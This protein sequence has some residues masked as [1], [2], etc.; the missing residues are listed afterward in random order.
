MSPTDA[1]VIVVTGGTGG[2]GLATAQALV[3]DSAHAEGGSN[4]LILTAR[5]VE[6]GR[7][8][9]GFADV[10]KLAEDQGGWE[11]VVMALQLD[12]EASV[13]AFKEE[14]EDRYGRIDVLVSNA[15]EYQ[16]D[17]SLRLPHVQSAPAPSFLIFILLHQ[18]RPH[19][20]GPH[21]QSL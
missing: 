7:H 21:G 8:A 19:L 16:C 9:A 3:E 6:K 10:E 1:R 5:S 13:Q 17:A 14:V 4:V 20:P 12:E 2:L 15:G 18:S 11:L